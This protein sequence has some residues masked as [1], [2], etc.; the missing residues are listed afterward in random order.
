MSE[1]YAN[2]LILY[3]LRQIGLNSI[4]CYSLGRCSVTHVALT[5]DLN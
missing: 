4:K 3:E 5:L 1:N 2:I